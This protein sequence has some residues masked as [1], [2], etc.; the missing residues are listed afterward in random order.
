MDQKN[1]VAEESS[2]FDKLPDELV[3]RIFQFTIES[4]EPW[5][6]WRNK[7]VW[8]PSFDFL[9]NTIA[10][11]SNRFKRIAADKSLWIWEINETIDSGDNKQYLKIETLLGKSL[12]DIYECKCPPNIS[13]V[14]TNVEGASTKILKSSVS[15]CHQ[16]CH[17]RCT[18]SEDFELCVDCSKAD[19]HHHQ[20]EK[21]GTIP[22]SGESEG[23][24]DAG[25]RITVQQAIQYLDHAC[26]CF[27]PNCQLPSCRKM[28]RIIAHNKTCKQKKG[29]CPICKQLQSLCCCHAKACK[30]LEC[31][32]P[33]CPHIK[34]LMLDQQM[35]QE[36]LQQRLREAAVMYRR[37]VRVNTI[38][39]IAPHK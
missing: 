30:E 9:S 22:S 21:Q 34:N 17:Y 5:M 35:R 24:T 11:L 28:K 7:S 13:V 32:V 15:I 23:G 14:M 29:S 8:I 38:I 12:V 16:W 4:V 31:P 36:K 18:I 3:L 19:S 1:P 6:K 20:M 10:R 39:K 37:I 2:P 25:S 33:H 26:H 27:D